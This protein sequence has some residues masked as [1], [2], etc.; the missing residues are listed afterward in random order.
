M[1][2]NFFRTTIIRGGILGE[3][4][5]TFITALNGAL[6]DPQYLTRER[7][8]RWIQMN[9]ILEEAIRGFT[10]SE[11]DRTLIEE[12]RTLLEAF[13]SRIQTQNNTD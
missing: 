10:I 3:T 5:A 8:D 2:N 13:E 6:G 9:G 7:Y 12:I 1:I 11:P 4:L